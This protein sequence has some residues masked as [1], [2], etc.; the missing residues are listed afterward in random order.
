[1][2][3]QSDRILHALEQGD[4][5]TPLDALSRFGCIRLAAR[6]FDLRRGGHDIQERLV[7]VETRNGTAE[8]AEYRLAP[9]GELF[10]TARRWE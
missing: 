10:A 3:S 9:A 6:I 1:M 5:L 2:E 7:P 8:V 4:R